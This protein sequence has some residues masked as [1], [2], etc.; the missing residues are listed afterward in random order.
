MT[1]IYTK[2]GDDGY[3]SLLG[4]KRIA[5]DSLRIEAYGTIDELNAFIGFAISQDASKDIQPLL[6]AIQRHLFRI[7]AILASDN[8]LEKEKRGLLFPLDH[9]EYLEQQ[10]DFLSESLPPL[11]HFILPGGSPAAC[12]LHAA[13]TVC[14]RAERRA[15]ALHQ[16]EPMDKAVLI[17]LNRL[18]DLL[19]VMARYQNAKDGVEEIIWND[20]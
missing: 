10:I 15:F 12:A 4:G 7:G 18:S 5:K 9:S 3:T 8:E 14:R 11:R 16:S 19:F 6:E 17:Y 1:K 13:R 2:T 20:E